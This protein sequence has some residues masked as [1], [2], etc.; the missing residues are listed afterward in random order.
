MYDLKEVPLFKN[1]KA[2]DLALI[3][4]K[5]IKR[6]YPEKRVVFVQGQGTD[7]LYIINSGMVKVLIMH[8]DGREKTL[9]ILNRGD[10]LGEVTLFGSELRSATVETLE[11]TSFL[12]ISKEDFKL[13]LYSIPDLSIRVIELL[14][15]RLRRANHQIEEL[16]FFTAR[17]RIICSLIHLVEEHGQDNKEKGIM[18]N[19]THTE[20]GRLVGVARETVTRVLN[21]LQDWGFITIEHKRI[22]VLKPDKLYKEVM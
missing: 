22:M 20:L 9:A 8:S 14:S 5:I 12:V 18:L 16:T 11:P 1:M 6:T 4:E 15:A 7:G 2:D 10:I 21:D 17:S 3:E 19:F 13:L